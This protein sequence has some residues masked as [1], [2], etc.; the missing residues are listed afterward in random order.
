MLYLVILRTSSRFRV[1][2]ESRISRYRA[3][4][5]PTRGLSHPRNIASNLMEL[6][7]YVRS[8]L[9]TR[10]RSSLTFQSRCCSVC[11]KYTHSS[12]VGSGTIVKFLSAA[13]GA[14]RNLQVLR[15]L[16]IIL[17]D[18]ILRFRASLVSRATRRRLFSTEKGDKTAGSKP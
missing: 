11:N 1:D 6:H 8:E 2:S 9:C 12:S 10:A 7:E 3:R 13:H 4:D 15:A 18:G 16:Q 17:L 5:T 14:A